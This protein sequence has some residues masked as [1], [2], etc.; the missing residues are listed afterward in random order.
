M[1]M[2][3]TQ[4]RNIETQLHF[5]DEYVS[6]T[7]LKETGCITFRIDDGAILVNMTEF[8]EFCER[9]DISLSE[10]E[11]VELLEYIEDTISQGIESQD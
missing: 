10:S 5:D 7:T 1:S 6:L 11:R 3:Y 2:N 9:D 8:A 4:L